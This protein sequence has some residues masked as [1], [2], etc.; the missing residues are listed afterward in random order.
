MKKVD[1]L[2]QK[3]EEM[4]RTEVLDNEGRRTTIGEIA[5]KELK[6]LKVENA[7]MALITT[8]LAMRQRWDETAR[9]RVE[10]FKANYADVKTLQDLKDLIH[11]MDEREFCKKV[12]N[13]KIGRTPFWRYVLLNNLVRAFTAYRIH[14]G[15]SDDWETIQHWAKNVNI[16]N[17]DNDMIGKINDVGLATVQNLRLICGIDTVKPD[18]HVKETLNE[19]GLGNEIEIVELLS[20]LLGYPSVELDQIFWHWDKNRSQRDEITIEEFEK[21]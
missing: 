8:V 1:F 12:L 17:L 13:L 15:F 6:S 11:S 5:R 7:A 2:R 19:I 3:I 9:P 18:V 14:K 21:L 10:A 20:E 4:R 16:R